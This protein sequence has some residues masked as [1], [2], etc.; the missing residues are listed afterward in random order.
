ML[1]ARPGLETLKPYTVEDIQWKIKL[2]ANECGNDLPPAVKAKVL[3]NVAAVSFN[4]YP[5]ITMKRLR[6][7]IGESHGYSMDNVLI[8]NGSN[9]LLTAICHVFGGVGRS[10]V[11]SNPSFSMYGIY[12]KMADS[13]PVAVD[14]AADY[15]FL[16]RNLFGCGGESFSIA[17]DR[18]QSQQS[19]RDCHS[20]GR[21]GKSAG[22]GGL[23]GDSR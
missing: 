9:G 22:R 15:R 16:R 21:S 7:M 14:L 10:I 18:L 6:T 5:D 12:A 4:R 1:A 23:S 11:F 19:H 8:G 20:T 3:E 17:V 2:D 13:Q